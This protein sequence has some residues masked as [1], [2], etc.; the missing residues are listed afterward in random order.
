MWGSNLSL[1]RE[2]LWALSFLEVVG[3]PGQGWGLWGDHVLGSPT[4]L[5]VGLLLF[6]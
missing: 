4:P 2:N 5:A 6:V 3:H 1:L